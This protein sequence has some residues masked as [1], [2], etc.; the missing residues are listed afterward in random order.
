MH[1]DMKTSPIGLGPPLAGRPSHTT[2]CTDHNNGGS[3]DQGQRLP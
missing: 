2:E 1:N 3:A